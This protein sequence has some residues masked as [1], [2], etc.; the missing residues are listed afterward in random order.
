M[1]PILGGYGDT[2]FRLR[3]PLYGRKTRKIQG[4]R[5]NMAHDYNKI[6]EFLVMRSLRV[7]RQRKREKANVLLGLPLELNCVNCLTSCTFNFGVE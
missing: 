3:V 7:S 4:K 1:R 5:A 2:L 6:R